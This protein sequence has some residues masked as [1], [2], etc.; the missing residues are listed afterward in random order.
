MSIQPPPCNDYKIVMIDRP[1]KETIA[2]RGMPGLFTSIDDDS[3]PWV[4]WGHVEL[5]M[6][7]FD[8]RENITYSHMRLTKSGVVGT[9]YHH[10]KVILLPIR[11]SFRYLEYDWVAKQG[12]FVVERPGEAHTLVT[13]D[14]DGCMF[15]GELHGPIDFYDENSNFVMTTD[16]FTWVELYETYCRQHNIPILDSLFI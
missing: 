4:P 13:D 9:H 8:L 15:F 1:G 2:R 14:P 16:V 10:G 3:N 7:G 12:D 6:L 5:K 11:G